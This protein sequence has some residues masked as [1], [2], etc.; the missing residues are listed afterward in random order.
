M[1]RLLRVNL[2]LADSSLYF[3]VQVHLCGIVERILPMIAF[4]RQPSDIDMPDA[5]VRF[6]PNT[7][8]GRQ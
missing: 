3:H 8:I 5:A 2:D 4:L 6:R 7:G 1:A